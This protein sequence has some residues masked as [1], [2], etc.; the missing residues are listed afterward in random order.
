MSI[1]TSLPPEDAAHLARVWRIVAETSK[2]QFPDDHVRY[3]Y[4][5]GRA[6]HYEDQSC[7]TKLPSISLPT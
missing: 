4:C 6:E 3:R 5:I 1:A 2:Q 7:H